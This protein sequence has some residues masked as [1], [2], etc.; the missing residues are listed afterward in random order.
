[1]ADITEWDVEN[2]TFWETTGKKIATRNLW[3][4]IPSLLCG[5]AVWMYWS[6]ITVQMLNLGFPF[7]QAELFTITAIAGFTGATFRIPQSFFIRIAGGRNTIFLTTAMLMI[8]AVGHRPRAAQ[9]GHAAVGV[10]APRLPVWPRRRQLRVVDV[11]HQLLLP[12]AHAGAGARPQRGARQRRRDHDA[13]PDPARD[14]PGDV[15]RRLDGA[16]TDFRHVDRQ[17]R[18]RHRDV[19]PERRIRVADLPD[20]AR[21]RRVVRDEQHPHRRGVTE[22]RRHDHGV[23]QGHWHVAG[24]RRSRG[25]RALS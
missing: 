15:R 5:F 20:T 13:A 22:H 9:Q 10:P 23:R 14:D 1:M 24:G 21:L 25:A 18:R 6:V 2:E 3:I 17:D 7:T 19:D 4:S 8:P 12:Q 11:E 16:R